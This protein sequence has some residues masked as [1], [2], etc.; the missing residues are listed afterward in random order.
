MLL[1]NKLTKN[2][3]LYKKIIRKPTTTRFTSQLISELDKRTSSI[4]LRPYQEE[5]IEVCLKKFEKEKIRR[6]IVSLPVGNRSL[7]LLSCY[8][9]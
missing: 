2:Y 3:S 7:N 1:F 6:Q 8:L 5:C 4:K 9:Y